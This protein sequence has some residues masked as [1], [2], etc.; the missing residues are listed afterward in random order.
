MYF[1]G[2][3]GITMSGSSYK[4]PDFYVILPVHEEVEY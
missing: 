3:K 2:F 1:K 4:K